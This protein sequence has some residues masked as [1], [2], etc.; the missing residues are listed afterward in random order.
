PMQLCLSFWANFKCCCPADMTEILAFW[1]NLCYSVSGFYLALACK[2]WRCPMRW[3][4]APFAGAASCPL[5]YGKGG[6]PMSTMEVLTLFL[7]IIGVC[8]L[9]IQMLNKKK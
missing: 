5:L 2:S 7:V 4:L 9:F 8:N 3:R 6:C 1:K